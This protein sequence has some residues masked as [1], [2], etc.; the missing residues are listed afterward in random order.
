MDISKL[1]VT[2]EE[3]DDFPYIPMTSRN[4]NEKCC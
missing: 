2:N 1:S 4:D 3:M